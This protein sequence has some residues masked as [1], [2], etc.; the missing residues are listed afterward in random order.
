MTEETLEFTVLINS[1]KIIE[2]QAVEAIIGGL[3][4]VDN[5]CTIVI[6]PV[7]PLEVYEYLANN[8]FMRIADIWTDQ[9]DWVISKQAFEKW[10]TS[11]AYAGKTKWDAEEND[12]Y[13]ALDEISMLFPSYHP[14]KTIAIKAKTKYQFPKLTGTPSLDSAASSIDM[15]EAARLYAVKVWEGQKPNGFISESII[16]FK[17]GAEWQAQRNKKARP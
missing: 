1:E 12:L 14:A 8:T 9:H 15:D 17:A 6:S 4:M 11:L 16:D 7:K 3:K 5:E 10:F 2:P 13:K